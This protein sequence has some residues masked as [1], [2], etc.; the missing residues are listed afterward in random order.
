MIV[1]DYRIAL[2]LHRLLVRQ[3]G[4]WLTLALPRAWERLDF[5]TE[6]K[7]QA[8]SPLIFSQTKAEFLVRSCVLTLVDYSVFLM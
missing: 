5:G 7:G 1:T 3:E 2:F 8:L 4:G 6:A